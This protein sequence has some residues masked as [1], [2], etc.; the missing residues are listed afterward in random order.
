MFL[1]KRSKRP[2]FDQQIEQDRWTPRAIAVL[3]TAKDL[4]LPHLISASHILLALETGNHQVSRLLKNLAIS[5]SAMLGQRA[6][7]S[8]SRKTELYHED[9]D[10]SLHELPHLAFE[11]AKAMGD[12]HVGIEHLL[13][14]LAHT[15]VPGVDLSYARI[16]QEWLRLMERG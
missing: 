11:E 1:R 14:F 12:S 13:L 9:F 4:A 10:R 5:P 15:G 2:L 7:S 16:K 3:S 6:P 8:W